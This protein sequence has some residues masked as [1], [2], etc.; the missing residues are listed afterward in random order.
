MKRMC[1]IPLLRRFRHLL[2]TV[3][4]LF[5]ALPGFASHFRYGNITWNRVPGN[6]LQIHFKVSQ[7]WRTSFYAS[8][9]SVGAVV[10][11][12]YTFDPGGGLPTVPINVTVTSVNATEDWFYGEFNYTAT[13]AA[14]GTYTAF[15]TNCCRISTLQNNHDLEFYVSSTVTVGNSNDAPVS[16]LPPFINLPA[17]AAAATYQLP[18]T[19]PN[20]DPL[21]YSLTPN[22]G[23]GTSTVQ[24]TG[25]S[26]SPS[27]LLTFNTIG[28]GIGDLYNS[29]VTIADNHGATIM[30]DFLIQITGQST[31]P[32]FDYPPTPANNFT[33]IVQP[34]QNINFTVKAEDNDSGAVVGLSG[35]GIP[36][37]ATFAPASGDPVQSAFN[38][39]PTNADL[40]TYLIN[41]TAQDNAGIQANTIVKLVV[42]LNP[43]FD[44]PQS[45][46]NGSLFCAPPG[47]PLSTTFQASDPDIHDS[48]SLSV[49]SGAV[50]GMSFAPAL[51][52]AY[53]N[54]VSTTLSWTPAATDW[55]VHQL[56]M[57]ATDSYGESTNDS[58]YYIVDNHPTF[59]SVPVLTVFAGQNYMYNGTTAD[60]D[61]PQGDHVGVESFSVPS[62]L[63]FTDNGNGTFSIHGTPSVADAG[64]Y[65]ISVEIEDSL[66]HYGGTHCGNAFQ[67]YVL[68]VIPCNITVSHVTT[69]NYCY[70][71]SSGTV[72]LTVN[73]AT[74]PVQY[75][76]SNGAA[77]KNLAGLPAGTYTL[78]LT[79]SNGCTARD[80][81]TI[82]Q[83]AQIMA[84]AVVNNVTTCSNGNNGS[85]SL[86]V[87]NGFS[88][89]TYSWSNGSH[90]KNISGLTAGPYTVTITDAHGC[91]R[92]ITYNIT[93]PAPLVISANVT[94]ISCRGACDGSIDVTITGGTPPYT[95]RWNGTLCGQSSLDRYN[96]CP[97]SYCLSVTDAHGCT[98]S[99]TYNITQ[100]PAICVSAVKNNVTCNGANDGSINLT[101]T[102]GTAPYTYHWSNNATTQ[103]LDNLAP[104]NYTVTVTDA[105]GCTYTTTYCV[106]QPSPFNP[107]ITASN[108][109]SCYG[110]GCANTDPTTIYIGYGPQCTTL[111][112][113]VPWSGGPYTYTWTA[114]S[115]TI[116]NPHSSCITVCPT[117]PTTYTLTVTNS[118]GCTVIKN[119]FIDVVNVQGPN[120]TIVLCHHPSG[121]GSQN[122]PN[123]T[124]YVQPCFV[125]T[126]LCHGDDLGACPSTGPVPRG[127]AGGDNT[128]GIEVPVAFNLY[129]NPSTGTFTLDIPDMTDA[130]RIIITDI[131][132]KTVETRM[133]DAHQPQKLQFNLSD[134]AKGIYLVEVRSGQDMYRSKVVIQ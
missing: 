107:S 13:Y 65:N 36:V 81:A 76:W 8:S 16:S 21:T 57:K 72:A 56:V 106:T 95:Y 51:P 18:A 53:H 22:G 52:T 62:F 77:T 61:I 39:T 130:S 41:F 58:V 115:G 64:N 128:A 54:P 31:P 37:G 7:A 79:D 109:S 114:T 44:L 104:G 127:I 90:N 110:Y 60:V 3:L 5:A 49:A 124:I 40:G 24:P 84:V 89:Y 80:T 78:L 70:G 120:G 123:Q 66:N 132:G 96:L 133:L 122:Q 11:T 48:V 4:I 94:N 29:N 93:A 73:N 103:D 9:L 83:A 38:W 14:N 86:T 42:S 34:G 10:S 82:T 33:Y 97:G 125:A 121:C 113:N 47:V 2:L 99:T 92:K 25:I 43:K 28:K 102:G 85:I 17:N 69:N 131:N 45:P 12:G 6:P 46:G 98:A 20:G 117:T 75:A 87:S 101:V 1:T 19:D 59:S 116:S 67:T 27:G 63:T 118:S 119:Q 100:P 26:I 112:A 126:H 71:D 74:N 68:Q 50:P 30:L 55:G 88:P 111:S 35:I 105:H 134:H 129:P 91:K 32:F 108:S 23:F 15:F